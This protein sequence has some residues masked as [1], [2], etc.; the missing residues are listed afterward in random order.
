MSVYLYS[1]EWPTTGGDRG[2]DGE[3]VTLRYVVTAQGDEDQALLD[4]AML[5]VAGSPV[6]VLGDPG[7]GKSHVEITIDDVP[8]EFEADFWATTGHP[9]RPAAWYRCDLTR[10]LPAAHRYPG[11]PG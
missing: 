4:R 11:S 10:D 8:R 9:H 1:V 2:R 6:V 5:A 3:R 7:A